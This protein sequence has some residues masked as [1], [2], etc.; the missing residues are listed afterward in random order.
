[1]ASLHSA[2]SCEFVC[3]AQD[4]QWSQLRWE[5]V[6]ASWAAALLGH[7]DYHRRDAESESIS[8]RACLLRKFRTRRPIPI[9]PAMLWGTFA[10][11]FV[12][13]AAAAVIGVPVHPSN[14]MFRSRR[15][16]RMTATIDGWCTP[17][18]DFVREARP[19]ML[20][21]SDAWLSELRHRVY[22][23]ARAHG[24]GL[25]EAKFKRAQAVFRPR[26]GESG[27]DD[28][29][30]L[31]NKF[32]HGPEPHGETWGVPRQHAYQLQHQLAVLGHRDGTGPQWALL[33][34]LI[35]GSDFRAWV[36]ERDDEFAELLG[37]EVSEFW[38]TLNGPDHDL[39]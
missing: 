23:L 26:R 11:T 2:A 29:T 15:F 9:R 3:T 33:V 10:E 19:E 7:D 8:E 1:M 32:G 12:L 18:P 17:D 6:G 39:R 5:S 35:G 24:P 38:E 21:G 36:L 37:R 13:E 22:A 25:V 31:R 14:G 20:E 27:R 16:P 28:A 30:Y 34:T 4:E